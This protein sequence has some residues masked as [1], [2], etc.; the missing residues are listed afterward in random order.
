MSACPQIGLL[1]GVAVLAAATSLVGVAAAGGPAMPPVCPS[2]A[3]RSAPPP[4]CI[5]KPWAESGAAPLAGSGKVT[6]VTKT[7]KGL[8]Y[9]FT[10]V[11]HYKNPFPI[12]PNPTPAGS[13][14]CQDTPQG[15]NIGPTGQYLPGAR[16][17]ASSP[18]SPLADSYGEPCPAAGPTC[19]L[20]YQLNASM[21]YG[22]VVLI[23]NVSVTDLT[24]NPN[25]NL[26]QA[27][28]E[29]PVVL[30]IQQFKGRP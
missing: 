8:E 29:F 2:S 19:T 27:G 26:G 30:S 20:H 12:C 18:A 7:R 16:T 25:N 28:F 10:V 21:T 17:L 22:R 14:P 1:G 9:M 3:Q 23:F 24:T 5:F 15:V 6:H 13:I 11:V 4:N